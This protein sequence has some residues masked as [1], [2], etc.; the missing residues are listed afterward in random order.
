[1]RVYLLVMCLGCASSPSR[2]ADTDV[3]ATKSRDADAQMLTITGGPYQKGS[4]EEEREK[5]YQDYR[6]SAQESTAGLTWRQPHRRRACRASSLIGALS[7]RLPTRNLFKHL[8]PVSRQSARRIGRPNALF[9]T[10]RARSRNTTGSRPVRLAASKTILLSWF[11]G[12]TRR[13]TA[14]GVVVLSGKRA[15]CQAPM[16]LKRQQEDLL[17]LPIHGA[18]SMSLRI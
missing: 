13:H 16:N 18:M 4:T 17:A 14:S 5:A 9:S 6:V 1:M 11:R 10:T 2:R 8:E 12:A 15:D 3:A 7:P